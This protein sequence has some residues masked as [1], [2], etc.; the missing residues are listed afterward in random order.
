MGDKTLNTLY[1]NFFSKNSSGN[2]ERI[3]QLPGFSYR[4][5]INPDYPLQDLYTLGLE[6][7]FLR[8]YLVAKPKIPDEKLSSAVI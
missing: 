5:E 1:A 8:R 3:I 6:S 7:G 4:V 2:Q